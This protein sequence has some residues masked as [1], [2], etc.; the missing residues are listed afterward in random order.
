MDDSASTLPRGN[1]V[2]RRTVLKRAGALGVATVW[3]VPVLQSTGVAHAVGSP[4]PGGGPTPPGG[5]D[6]LPLRGVLVVNIDG[7]TDKVALSI[8][9]GGNTLDRT[10]N[11]EDSTF[12]TSKVGT[13]RDATS[14]ERN[15]FSTF[16][17]TT[18]AGSAAL[19]VTL[20]AGVT[21]VDG[22]T[23]TFDGSFFSCGD[24]DKYTGAYRS[25]TTVYFVRTCNE[26]SSGE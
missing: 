8:Y 12:I 21:F 2:D 7:G 25:G 3:A 22:I 24:G 16:G 26:P 15:R 4:L 1:G 20:P 10:I 17:A 18:Y 19:F 5:I 23:Y 9:N 6:Q 14:A 11:N 13:W